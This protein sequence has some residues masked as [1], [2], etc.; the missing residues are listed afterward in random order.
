VQSTRTPVVDED[1][2]L[3]RVLGTVRDVTRERALEA[4][5]RE[6]QAFREAFE[7]APLGQALLSLDGDV[8]TIV[9]ANEHFA[10][11]VGHPGATLAG[12]PLDAVLAGGTD[13]AAVLADLG[14]DGEQQAAT[15]TVVDA[16]GRPRE[17]VLATQ[18]LAGGSLVLL[19]AVVPSAEQPDAG[20]AT[21]LSERERGILELVAS[22]HGGNEI[23][24]ELNLGPETVKTHLRR[25]YSKLGVSDRAAAVAVALRRGFIQ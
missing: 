13:R 9:H 5:A 8:P 24:E 12:R 6:A 10:Q 11:C 19:S 3:T 18:S 16:A 23:A 14:D 22:G 21:R 7:V 25:T 4:A 20:R 15:L 1:G 17:V 2:H